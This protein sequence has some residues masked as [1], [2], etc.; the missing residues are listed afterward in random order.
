MNARER[1]VIL[2]ID[3]DA[4]IRALL[5]ALLRREG[6][7]AESAGNVDDALRL[8]SSGRHAAVIIDPEI[9]AGEAL[10][11]ALQTDADERSRGGKVIVMTTPEASHEPYREQPGVHA[12]LFKPLFLAEVAATVAACCDEQT[13]SSFAHR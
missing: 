4:A 10:L 12:V 5:V 2:V 8:H 6:Y 1:N 11:H 9:Q 7:L 3:P 13:P